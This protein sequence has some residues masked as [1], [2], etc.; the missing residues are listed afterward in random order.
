MKNIFTDDQAFRNPDEEMSFSADMKQAADLTLPTGGRAI[1]WVALL[2]VVIFISWATWVEMDEITRGDG[3]VIPSSQIQD[4]QN[5]E[6][7]IVSELLVK[8]G[9]IVEKGQVLLVLDDTQFMSSLGGQEVNRQSLDIKRIRLQAEID[10]DEPFIPDVVWREAPDMAQQEL[11]LY[12]SRLEELQGRKDVFLE[13][14]Q[15]QKSQQEEVRAQRKQ[16]QRRMTLLKEE[17]EIASGL[18][19]IGAVS[20][21]EVIRLERQV[22]DTEGELDVNRKMI[23]RL[24]SQQQETLQRINEVQLTFISG[25]RAELNETV[26]RLKELEATGAAL[27]DRVDRAQVRSPVKGVVK[28]IIANT[29]GG[30]VQPGMKMME[31]VPLGDKLLIETRIRPQDIGFLH[32]G[33]KAVVRFTAY[34]FTVYGGLDGN[35]VHLGADTITDEKGESFYIAHIE[36]N[37]NSIDD[38]MPV[39]TGMVANVDIL[40]GKKSLMS[41]LMKPVLR[42]K[43]LAFSER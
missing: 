10:G 43:Q 27:S 29:E 38:S 7:G 6:G 22:S 15:Q 35:L 28:Q 2:A 5:L 33:Q 1:I 9:D 31:I 25:A 42:A 16:L 41:Y 23:Q 40:T 4:V 14:I 39:I 36:T 20:R 19:K 26:A 17:L 12:Y 21:I 8:E 34:D 37:T 30:V 3:K 32:P 24:G 11:N 13:Q 18:A